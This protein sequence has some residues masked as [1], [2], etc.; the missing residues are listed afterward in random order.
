MFQ[1]SLIPWEYGIRNLFRRPLRTLLTLTGLT[2]VIVLV[3]VVIGFI[4]GL[5]HSLT[6]SGDPQVAL[7]FSLGMGENLE[8]SSIPMRTNELVSAS[9]EGIKSFH[10]RK[11]VSPELFLGTQ[12]EIP[13]QQETAMGLV[14]G[15]PE[16]VLVCK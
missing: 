4:R 1:F 14:S 11:Y 2:T 5:E 9:V 7:L 6:V 3:F 16:S 15:C 8:Y 12:I 13:G 10:N